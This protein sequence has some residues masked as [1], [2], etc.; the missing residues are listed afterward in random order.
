MTH[1]QITNQQLVNGKIPN[2]LITEGVTSLDLSF[3]YD[4]TSLS[5]LPKSLKSL[6]VSYSDELSS[7]SGLPEGLT[8]LTAANCDKLNTISDLPEGLTHL[9]A[10]NCDNLDT[11]SNLPKGLID[12]DF[13]RCSKIRTVPELPENLISLNFASCFGLETLSG[14]LPKKLKTLDLSN[15]VSLSAFPDFPE[16]LTN[17]TLKNLR[18]QILQELPKN[19]RVLDLSECTEIETLPNLPNT[20]QTLNLFNCSGLTT[21]PNL[22]DELEYLDLLLCW[23]LTPDVELV[24]RLSDLEDRGCRITYPDHFVR[25]GEGDQI[26]KRLD[27]AI[28]EYKN[29]HNDQAIPSSIRELF[30]RFLTEGL[31]QRSDG[32]DQDKKI[33]DIALR[34]LPVIELFE[35]NPNHLEWA[36]EIAKAY[37][38][39]CVNQPENGMS[40]LGAFAAIV[41]AEGLPAKIR[42]TDQ[43]RVFELVKAF[44]AKPDLANPLGTHVE[45]EAGNACFR[46]VYKALCEKKDDSGKKLITQPWIG[47]PKSLAYEGMIANWMKNIK[48]S[49]QFEALTA[50]ARSI[51]INPDLTSNA[52]Y[53]CNTHHYDN[54]ASIA[55]PTEVARVNSFYEN[56]LDFVDELRKPAEENKKS[57]EEILSSSTYPEEDKEKLGKFYKELSDKANKDGVEIKTA[58]D[59]VMA[60]FSN[61]KNGAIKAIVETK[62]LKATQASVITTQAG[63]VGAS[64]QAVYDDGSGVSPTLPFVGANLGAVQVGNVSNLLR[65]LDDDGSGVSPPPRTNNN[66]AS[67][68]TTFPQDDEAEA[69]PQ[70]PQANT[71]PKP[72]WRRAIDAIANIFQKQNRV[73]IDPIEQL[74]ETTNQPQRQTTSAPQKSIRGTTSARVHPQQPNIDVTPAAAKQLQVG[75]LDRDGR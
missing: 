24:S 67:S 3:C 9:T 66:K 73:A 45:V 64:V 1:L 13:H 71:T 11:I 12:L 30:S 22:P 61:E 50:Q 40:E 46:E 42:A 47:V 36:E 27:D 32:V 62:T 4:L 48:T 63:S 59:Q 57:A 26:I 65:A 25:I 60:S 19:L 23:S 39:G 6:V 74:Q 51:V 18:L 33:R 70:A 69:I 37:L 49:G 68:E 35:S 56:K 7:F 14:N 10:A 2:G 17:L 43:L 20:I 34:T 8:H 54:W 38:A 29:S 15:C 53:L 44:V 5:G 52:N 55:F 75:V 28:E 31:G 58:L 21:L 16:E 41:K 72:W